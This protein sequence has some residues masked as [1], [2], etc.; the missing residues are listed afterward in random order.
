[1]AEQ[2]LV[3]QG[4]WAQ[5]EDKLKAVV[6]TGKGSDIDLP[7]DL[8][9]LIA[10]RRM[11]LAR[12][13]EPDAEF[14]CPAAMVLVPAAFFE[15]SPDGLVRRPFLN[16]GNYRLTGQVHYLG[17]AATGRSRDY[18]GDDG[19]LL[20]ALAADHADILPTVIYL[21][22]AGGHSK[23]SWFPFGVAQ[24]DKVQTLPVAPEPP[25]P[26]RIRHVIDAV[27]E[28]ELKS[29]DQVGASFSLWKDP[30]KGRAGPRRTPRSACSTRCAWV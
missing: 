24:D 19:A 30:A 7:E 11:V 20:D 9:F 18:A 6:L 13:R 25:T 14:D 10:V 1:M 21:P 28:H 23:L 16:S 5:D 17:V 27:Y 29:P 8:R 4:A 2:P 12:E 3:D 22:K 15:A 26:E